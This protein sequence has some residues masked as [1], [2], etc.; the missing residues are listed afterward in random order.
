M[1]LKELVAEVAADLNLTLAEGRAAVDSVI[2]SIKDS[3][4]RKEEVTLRGFGSFSVKTTKARVGRN[5]Q[6]SEALAIPAG[7]KISF[8]PSK[9]GK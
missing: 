7:E 9:A 1:T 2:D 5:P 8:K 3:L 6:T 4:A